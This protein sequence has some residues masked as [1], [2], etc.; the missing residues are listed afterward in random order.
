[1][2]SAEQRAQGRPQR[3]LRRNVAPPD[4]KDHA[5]HWTMDTLRGKHNLTLY[6]SIMGQYNTLMIPCLYRIHTIVSFN[7]SNK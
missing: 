2:V 1:M 7:F 6:F 3:E 5:G 4:V